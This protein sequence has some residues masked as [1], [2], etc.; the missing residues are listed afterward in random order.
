MPAQPPGFRDTL[1]R[2]VV[3]RRVE[4]GDRLAGGRPGGQAD[5]SPDDPPA[6]LVTGD[7]LDIDMLREAE[8][9]VGADDVRGE[10]FVVAGRAGEA[11]RGTRQSEAGA[12]G[13]AA[14]RHAPAPG[15]P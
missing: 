12:R 2:D 15:W 5:L 3:E 13:R 14:T 10:P 4:V 1:A 11:G 7:R 8:H 9:P 6:E